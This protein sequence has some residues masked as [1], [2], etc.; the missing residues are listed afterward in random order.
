[1]TKIVS[2]E[3]KKGFVIPTLI[4]LLGIAII[5]LNITLYPH[6]LPQTITS[7]NNSLIQQQAYAFYI[8]LVAGMISILFGLRKLYSYYKNKSGNTLGDATNSS[9]FFQPGLASPSSMPKPSLISI[10]INIV[11]N[12]SYYFKVFLPVL[13]SYGIFYSFVSSMLIVRPEGLYHTMR[14]TAPSAIIM[15]HGPVGY[16]PTIALAITDHIG[17]LIIPI[18][19]VILCVVSALVGLNAVLLAYAFQNRPR[20]NRFSATN[21]TPHPINGSSPFMAGIG[22]S[23]AIFAVCPTCASL[24]IFGILAG[25]FASTITSFAVSFYGLFAAISIP[26]LLISPIVTASSIRKAFGPNI[27]YFKK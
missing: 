4:I 2:Y 8:V 14:I 3:R 5:G 7:E 16:A 18:N 6:F 21:K 12:R 11:G 13:V 26:L 17:L 24:Y 22:A 9:S 20:N 27:C 15:T 19:L 25:S 23:A 10:I 1:L